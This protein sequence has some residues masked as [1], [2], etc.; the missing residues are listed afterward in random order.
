MILFN[1]ETALKLSRNIGEKN[2]CGSKYL[3]D[4]EEG[5]QTSWD[6][7]SP[8]EYRSPRRGMTQLGS[9]GVAEPV[10]RLAY[11]RLGCPTHLASYERST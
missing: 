7:W 4:E 3:F 10:Y 2:Q 6:L 5:T 1:P 9:D 8:L 11:L